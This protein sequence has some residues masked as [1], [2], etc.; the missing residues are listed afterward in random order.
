[1]KENNSGFSTPSMLL[2]I[3][4]LS[5]ILSGITV[6]INSIS[7]RINREK[8]VFTQKHDAEEVLNAILDDFQKLKEDECDSEKSIEKRNLLEKYSAYNL[9]M[10]DC[11][12]G[13]NLN[14]LSKKYAESSVLERFLEINPERVVKY[15]W[16]YEF[17]SDKELINQIL[18]DFN[19]EKIN[20][21][22][23]LVSKIAPLNIYEMDQNFLEVIFA[24]NKVADFKDKAELLIEKMKQEDI[25]SSSIPSIIGVNPS[26]PVVNWLGVKTVFWKI[27]CNTEK[28]DVNAVI[29][30]IAED[31]NPTLIDKYILIESECNKRRN[32]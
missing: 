28:M 18:Q 31:K 7:T 8:E 21:L 13:I 12:T 5:I 3:F 16:I 20:E 1:M 26:H 4:S 14:F 19:E 9:V 32:I 15:G 23:P 11:S 10:N 24:I 25:K 30:G 27:S 22:N 2:L 17:N 29:A 6:L